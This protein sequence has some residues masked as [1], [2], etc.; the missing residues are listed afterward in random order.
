MVYVF[1][2]KQLIVIFCVCVS[3]GQQYVTFA[4]HFMSS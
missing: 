1:G 3:L 2:K 4:L